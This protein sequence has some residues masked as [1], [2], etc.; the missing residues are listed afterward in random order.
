MLQFFFLEFPF[1]Q[2]DQIGQQFQQQF[3][4]PQFQQQ[5]GVLP[6]SGASPQF[7]A[8]PQVQQTSSEC[9]I[10]NNNAFKGQCV[11]LEYCRSLYQLLTATR[12][13]PDR[14]L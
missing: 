1:N 7:G 13:L 10:P 12:P 3:G 9:A 11:R 4:I 14:G 5:F 8:S 2:F 6:L